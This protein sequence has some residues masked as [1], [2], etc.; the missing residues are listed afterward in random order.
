MNADPNAD[1]STK[2]VL[3]LMLRSKRNLSVVS[4]RYAV[5]LS[6]IKR[7]SWQVLQGG[8]CHVDDILEVQS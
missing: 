5:A 2:L 1:R 4:L 7:E 6:R 3:W 8:L